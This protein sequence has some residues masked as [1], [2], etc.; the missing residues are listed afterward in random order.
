MGTQIRSR[1]AAAAAI[2]ALGVAGIGCS[3][4]KEQ[5]AP[6]ATPAVTL[7]KQRVALGSPIE[8]TYRFTVAPGA[9]KFTED[10]TA[11]VHFVETN[12]ELMWTDDHQPIIPTSK[13]KPGQTIET[14]RS[15][16]VPIYP[17]VGQA[18]VHV[19][20]YSRGSNRRLPLAGDDRG[21]RSYKVATLELLP[22][23]ENVFLIYKD[24]WHQAEVNPENAAVEWQWTKGRAVVSFRNPRRDATLYLEGDGRADLFPVPQQV[25]VSMGGQLVDSFAMSNRDPVL[26]KM[27]ITAVQ[28]GTGDMVDL[29]I[30]VD[31][32]FVPASTPAIGGNDVRELGIR[33]YHLFVEPK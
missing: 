14:R 4:K 30:A 7:S 23:S 6:V 16:F 5:E 9:P 22:Q 27:A 29:E 10:Y 1:V 2:L 17:Y 8:V 26:R 15:I 28:F 33:V 20:L 25:S 12:E 19:G 11:F 13:W 18:A 24:G 32:T 21:M 3:S 31:K